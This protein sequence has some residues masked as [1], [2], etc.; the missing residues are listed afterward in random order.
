MSR[1][2]SIAAPQAQY[3]NFP[4]IG[5]KIHTSFHTQRARNLYA[6]HHDARLTWHAYQDRTLCVMM[7]YVIPGRTLAWLPIVIAMAD[8]FAA[9]REILEDADD[10]GDG[11]LRVQN[12]EVLWKTNGTETIAGMPRDTTT[13]VDEDNVAAV[14]HMLKQRSGLDSILVTMEH[15]PAPIMDPTLEEL[16]VDLTSFIHRDARNNS[17]ASKEKA[18]Q[19]RPIQSKRPSNK[20]RKVSTASTSQKVAKAAPTS[21]S[22]NIAAGRLAS[23]SNQA[24]ILRAQPSTI[25]LPESSK[26]IGSKDTEQHTATKRKRQTSPVS[27][28]NE[29]NRQAVSTP[30]VEGRDKRP[31]DPARDMAG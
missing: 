21:I 30:S 6:L 3:V 19:G 14:L 16:E 10:S 29:V 17:S 28:S 9:I 7:L 27:E 26:T 1:P 20:S 23:D 31:Y 15:A 2:L 11:S 18:P 12:L 8:D 25:E 5:D 22:G 13:W 24:L 4:L